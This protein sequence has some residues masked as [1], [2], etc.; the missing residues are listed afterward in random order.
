MC[1]SQ[2]S[3]DRRRSSTTTATVS[4]NRPNNS[5][6]Q[7]SIPTDSTTINAEGLTRQQTEARAEIDALRKELAATRKEL[8]EMRAQNAQQ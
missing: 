3:T 2:H 5:Q 7:Q 4:A 8:A 1:N 6:P